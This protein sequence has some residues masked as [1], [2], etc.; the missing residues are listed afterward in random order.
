MEIR[1]EIQFFNQAGKW[2]YWSDAMDEEHA[3]EIVNEFIPT[4]AAPNPIRAVKVITT[5]EV[6]CVADTARDS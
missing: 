5:I 4:K 6:L 3:R 1:Y 2:T